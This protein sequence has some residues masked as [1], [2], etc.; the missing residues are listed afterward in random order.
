MAISSCA[1][2]VPASSSASSAPSRTIGCREPRTSSASATLPLRF[3][4]RRPAPKRGERVLHRL[5]RSSSA[6]A[7]R[8]R[9]LRA[10]PISRVRCAARCSNS[11]ATRICRRR[12]RATRRA[13]R[14]NNRTS[15]S[16]RCRSSGTSTPTARSWAARWCCRVELPTNDREML[17]RLVAKWEKERSDAARNLTLAG[18]TLPPFHRSASGRVGEEV[19][20]DPTRGAA[21]PRASS[22]RRRS[23]ST[24]TR[25]TCAATRTAPRA[26][27]R[28]RRSRASATRA[29]ASSASGPPRSRCRSR[30][31]SPARSTFATSCRGLV[32]RGVRRACACPRRHPLRGARERP[33]P[34]RRGALLRPRALPAGGGPMT[35]TD[36]RLRRIP[37]GRAR[38]QAALCVAA[39]PARA[40]RP[41][42]ALAP[43]AG[44]PDRRGKDDLHRHRPLRARARRRRQS[45]GPLVPASHRDGRGPPHRGRSGRGARAHPSSR[46]DDEHGRGRRR[47]GETAPLP[48]LATGEEPLGVFTLRGG[49]PKDDGWARTPDQPLVIAS[50][51]DQS[52][53]PHAHAGLRREPGH[54]AGAC[55]PPGQRHTAPPRRG[56]PLGAVPADPRP[57]RAP[58]YAILCRRREDAVLARVP[59]R[60]AKR[61]DRTHLSHCSTRRRSPTR[62][63]DRA[64]TRASPCAS[65][66]WRIGPA[67]EKACVDAGDSAARTA[68]HGRRGRQPRRER[69]RDR[70][71]A[72]RV[73]S[74]A[75][76]SSPCSPAACARWTVTTCSASCGP[77][78]DGP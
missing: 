40:D 59:V 32:A 14:P 36:L 53:I 77:R 30:R 15:R 65:S 3:Q 42:Q 68:P 48:E 41:R 55:G 9:S 76:R 28:W 13:V 46:L 5:G 72:H 19:A 25:A 4:G 61:W 24:R 49:M 11:T 20:L 27:P 47:G 51:V 69:E 70:T 66:R 10:P 1:W 23:P 7:D 71:A 8:G 78:P 37:R 54:E 29:S 63:S 33:A 43:R 16:S 74:A 50:T 18:G 44:P 64:S 39:A 6:L 62:R 45:E 67:L 34:A 17:L 73:C 26:R 58:P 60:D 35:L 21:P 22:P 57:A 38:R 31:C 12:S 2:S 52:R 56:A 75:M